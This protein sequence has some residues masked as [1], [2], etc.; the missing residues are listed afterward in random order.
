M[1]VDKINNSLT[2]CLPEQKQV[3]SASL[4]C[5]ACNVDGRDTG[6]HSGRLTKFFFE[7][8]RVFNYPNMTRKRKV[9]SCRTAGVIEIYLH[10]LESYISSWNYGVLLYLMP[11]YCFIKHFVKHF[12]KS[13]F[14]KK[15]KT[16]LEETF[17]YA[18]YKMKENYKSAY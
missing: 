12:R 1:H 13:M 15:L 18:S 10:F 7:I 4:Y 3:I 17:M 14:S 11:I 2:F 9:P 16:E 8:F 5:I 6:R